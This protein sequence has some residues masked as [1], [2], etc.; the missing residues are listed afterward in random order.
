[1]TQENLLTYIANSMNLIGKYNSKLYNKYKLL[2]NCELEDK[3]L[4]L[5][6][7]AITETSN[8]YNGCSCL[9]EKDICKFLEFIN[10]KLKS[11]GK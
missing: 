6:F 11:N 4:I 3:L 1:M 9:E 8:Y 5:S 10:T 7:A 2:L